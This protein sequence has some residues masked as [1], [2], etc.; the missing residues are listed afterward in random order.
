MLTPHDRAIAHHRAVRATL[1]GDG[2]VT[3]LNIG[4]DEVW[5][6]VST[7]DGVVRAMPLEIGAER[8]ARELLR[9][10]PP[11]RAEFEM[12]IE[13]I[14]DEIT[15]V[16]PMLAPNSRLV[17]DDAGVR[18]IAALAGLAGAER[19]TLF[20]GDTEQV[21]ARLAAMVLGQPARAAGIPQDNAFAIRL[22]VLREFLHHLGFQ[23]ITVL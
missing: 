21:F 14:E 3:L 19:I 9:H 11:H 13:P 6:S 7:A 1:G 16:V 2:A 20:I 4:A 22:I 8:T 10:C 23:Q 15:R 18:E 17:T 12:A 5:V